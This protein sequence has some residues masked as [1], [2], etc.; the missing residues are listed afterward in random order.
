MG[1]T[2]HCSGSESKSKQSIYVQYELKFLPYVFDAWMI[3]SMDVKS[4]CRELESSLYLM[5]YMGSGRRKP[6]FFKNLKHK[7]S[8]FLS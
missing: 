4:G 1:T 3:V 8:L 7:P 6:I 5:M 2:Q